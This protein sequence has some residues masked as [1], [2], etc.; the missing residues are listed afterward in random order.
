[1]H[2]LNYFFFVGV[3]RHTSNILKRRVA[4][5]LGWGGVRRDGTADVDKNLA[6]SREMR[7]T[8]RSEAFAECN[9]LGFQPRL[10]VKGG[11]AGRGAG[12]GSHHHLLVTR[13]TLGFFCDGESTGKHTL[14]LG[15]VV[16]GLGGGHPCQT[17]AHAG[18]SMFC[19]LLLASCCALLRVRPPLWT[20]PA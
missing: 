11:C 20:S 10:C 4:V 2:V 14:S 7:I 9:S 5:V 8:E 1:M 6:R 19:L 15:S 13:N 17:D 12:V 18:F 3:S 16:R